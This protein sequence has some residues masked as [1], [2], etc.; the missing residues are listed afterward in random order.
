MPN[1][2]KEPYAVEPRRLPSGRWKGRVVRYDSETGKRR[3]LTQTFDTKREAKQ[4]AET[5]AAKYR[6]D[7]NRKPPSEETFASF[8]TAW[9]DG[10]AAARTRDTT[11]KAYRRYGKPLL[12]AV[13]H[14]PLKALTPGDFQSILTQMIK[15]GRATSTIHHVYV[16]AHSSLDHAVS[17][18]L[19][20]FNPTHR[21]KPPRV[22]S[23]EIVPPTAAESQVLL[24]TA[25]GDRLKAL[26]WFIALTGCRKGEAIALK[27]VD[28]DWGGHVAKIQRTVAA[29]GGL[30]SIHDAKT[31]K[32]RRS[33]ALS[34]YLMD[35]LQE[36]QTRQRVEHDLFGSHWN[37]EGWVF[38]SEKG[39]LFWPSNI[40]R[41]FRSLR[42]RAGLPDALRPHDL[43]HA[44]ATAW[45]TADPP[46]PVKVVSERLGHA[47][48]NITLQIYGHLLPNMQHEAAD[49][50]DFLLR[51]DGPQ[52]G[53][54]KGDKTPS[55][56]S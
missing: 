48:I 38:P 43:R 54:R 12:Q 33:I 3:E 6:E 39:T 17:L 56:D 2:V 7:P 9:I 24:N 55:D 40:N 42:K 51:P 49:R 32:G 5:E 21:V 22:V 36:H 18:G 30:R 29:D 45:L 46:V 11:A 53:R 14:K 52:T 23:P 44:M 28:I 26:W 34:D 1:R 4:W 47:N 50:L 19:I 10:V 35:I 31:T 41:H 27:W 16:V 8:F 20:P 13:G 15:D 25:E 37:S